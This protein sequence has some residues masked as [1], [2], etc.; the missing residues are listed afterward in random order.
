M[1][2][3]VKVWPSK[4][5]ARG[6]VGATANLDSSCAR[7]LCNTAGRGEETGFQVEQRN[8]SRKQE[9]E[10]AA[11]KPL[12]NKDPIQGHSEAE[13]F[14]VPHFLATQY[15]R[16]KGIKPQ[17]PNGIV[18]SVSFVSTTNTARSLAGFVLLALALTPWRSP[19]SSEKLCPAS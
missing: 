5:R 8:R 6:K 1:L 15:L 18:S 9:R 10:I 4:G 7:R 17:F 12:D 14:G 3:A 11:L 2:E 13:R 19:G 16:T